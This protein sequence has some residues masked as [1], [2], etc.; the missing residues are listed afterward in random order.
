MDYIFFSAILSVILL[1]IAISYDIVCQWKI[2]LRERMHWLPEHV[3]QQEPGVPPLEKRMRYGLPVWHASAHEE[4]CQ[5]ANSLRLQPGLAHTD[6]EGVERGWSRINGLSSSTKE[7]GQGAQHDTLDD[8]FGYHN[9][10]RNIGLGLSS[11]LVIRCF[12]INRACRR[13]FDEKANHSN[14]R[15]KLPN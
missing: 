14:R 2:N 3:T 9:W 10:Q 6:G 4:N 5:I 15:A 7:M 12:K 11:H 1:A 13:L 8:H